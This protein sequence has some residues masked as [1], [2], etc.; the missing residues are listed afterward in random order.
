MASISTRM[1]TK[2]AAVAGALGLAVALGAPAAGAQEDASGPDFGSLFGIL[3][4]GAVEG[5][6][7]GSLTAEGADTGSAGSLGAF[8]NPGSLTEGAQ[9]AQGSTSGSAGSIGEVAGLLN[10]QGF[11]NVVGGSIES[12]SAED[13]GATGSLGEIP[14]SSIGNFFDTLENVADN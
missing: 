7:T 10:P 6:V 5:S 4:L 1:F 14:E 13:Q 9:T 8:L 2:S 11:G 12:M 3:N